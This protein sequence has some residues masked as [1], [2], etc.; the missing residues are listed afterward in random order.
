MPILRRGSTSNAALTEGVLWGVPRRDGASDTDDPLAHVGVVQHAFV[1]GQDDRAVCGFKTP[2]YPT[3]ADRSS[4]P[5][6]ALAGPD[7]AK[8]PRCRA[9]LASSGGTLEVLAPATEPAGDGQEPLLDIQPL[10]SVD[11]DA[12]EIPSATDV[13]AEEAR[14]DDPPGRETNG[15]EDDATRESA[16]PDARL[17]TTVRRRASVR[18]GG[19]VTV[20]TGRRSVAVQLPSFARGSAIAA[21]IDGDPGD[22]QVEAVTVTK[23]GLAQVTLNARA[24]T[25][26]D[27]VIYIVG[28][29]SA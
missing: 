9:V 4:R 29:R 14:Q 22:M 24:T 19:R 3:V 6:L 25:P 27:V 16:E 10:A 11:G 2:R 1:L 21:E 28:R 20:P 17:S 13:G 12:T 7:N 15:R 18:Q 5:R 8:C 26:I 23:D